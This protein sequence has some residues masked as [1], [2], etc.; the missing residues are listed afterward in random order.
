MPFDFLKFNVAL[1]NKN[2]QSSPGLDG[3][4]FEIIH[5]LPI[6]Y[7]V[8]LVDIFNSMYLNNEYRNS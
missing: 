4:D 6:K 8:L 3:I 7:K 2:E 1:E 5:R